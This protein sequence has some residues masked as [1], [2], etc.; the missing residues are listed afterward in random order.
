[1]EGLTEPDYVVLGRLVLHGEAPA[2]VQSMRALAEVILKYTLKHQP[3]LL[4][5]TEGSDGRNTFIY[6]IFP[7]ALI[8]G[9]IKALQQNRVE[10]DS[11]LIQAAKTLGETLLEIIGP[12][13]GQSVLFGDAISIRRL[14]ASM[15]V[16]Q[17]IGNDP[18]D[19]EKIRQGERLREKLIGSIW[20]HKGKYQERTRRLRVLLPLWLWGFGRLTYV[21]QSKI[22]LQIGLS[23][24]EIPEEDTLRKFLSY[25]R[26]PSLLATLGLK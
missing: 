21:Q 22:F 14:A 1:M 25:Y 26:I 16:A 24:S 4:K 5:A 3:T 9:A 6:L 15:E 10:I 19:H 8:Y 12:K 20:G 7:L 13:I 23:E 11:P 18:T 17:S 2:D